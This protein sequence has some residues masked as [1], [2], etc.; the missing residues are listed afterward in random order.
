MQPAS[1]LSLQ[2]G[3]D[4][5]IEARGDEHLYRLQCLAGNVQSAMIAKRRAISLAMGLAI[6]SRDAHV[7]QLF[8]SADCT[9]LAAAWHA[10]RRVIEGHALPHPEAESTAQAV[11]AGAYLDAILAG[12]IV[13]L[14]S[15][16]LSY[17]SADDI[18]YITNAYG[19]DAVRVGRPTLDLVAG[20]VSD[21]LA[22]RDYGPTPTPI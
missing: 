21:M 17:D 14:N 18:T 16:R 7:P 13:S 15:H 22:G 1:L 5:A 9:L 2:A 8:A 3:L 19:I 11:S 20:F 10:G 12:Q 4:L 6:V